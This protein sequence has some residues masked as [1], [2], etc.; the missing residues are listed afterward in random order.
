MCLFFIVSMDKSN[1][2]SCVSVFEDLSNEAKI[3]I[4]N[5]VISDKMERGELLSQEEYDRTRLI[6]VNVLYME[7]CN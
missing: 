3:K 1:N 4:F 2:E 7:G 5:V 6:L